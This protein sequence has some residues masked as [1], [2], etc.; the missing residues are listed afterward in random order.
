[1]WHIACDGRRSPSYANRIH[2]SDYNSFLVMVTRI[3]ERFQNERNG[4]GKK[5]RQCRG[6]NESEHVFAFEVIGAF[7]IEWFGIRSF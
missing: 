2:L 7:R 3:R 6:L 1:M 4:K 5:R